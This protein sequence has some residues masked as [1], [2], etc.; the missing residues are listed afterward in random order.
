MPNYYRPPLG[1][2]PEVAATAGHAWPALRW[3]LGCSGLAAV[4]TGLFFAAWAFLAPDPARTVQEGFMPL[5][6]T[7]AFAI[8]IPVSI[9]FAIAS[10]RHLWRARRRLA[11]V[12]PLML[13]PVA[14]IAPPS[15]VFGMGLSPDVALWSIPLGL[16]LSVAASITAI[17]LIRPQ[18]S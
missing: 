14:A 8:A 4:L 1:D 13:L 10:T 3:P 15:A 9:V 7:A 12:V 18:L 5:L 17:V 16:A 2:K 11:S 6:A